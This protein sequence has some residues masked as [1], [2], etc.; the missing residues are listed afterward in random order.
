M[1]SRWSTQNSRTGRSPKVTDDLGNRVRNGS[2]RSDHPRGVIVGEAYT[3]IPR[4]NIHRV[5]TEA[6][7]MDS[8]HSDWMQYS[9][10]MGDYGDSHARN[11]M[12]T[13]IRL[14]TTQEIDNHGMSSALLEDR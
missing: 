14:S 1:D 5:T 8:L 6:K 13:V 11:G 4:S 7:P 2:S 12:E 10:S 3:P 9:F